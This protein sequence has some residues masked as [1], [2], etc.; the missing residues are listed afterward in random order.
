MNESCNRIQATG[1]YSSR[2]RRLLSFRPFFDA[3]HTGP[4]SANIAA[5]CHQVGHA[6]TVS[7]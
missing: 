7:H 3:L 4:L 5:L 2:F 1:A 6:L